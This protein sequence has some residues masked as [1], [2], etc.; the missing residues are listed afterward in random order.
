[1][2]CWM[3]KHNISILLYNFTITLN[4][5]HLFQEYLS[6]TA[7]RR[8]KRWL[9]SRSLWSEI[10]RNVTEN[11]TTTCRFQIEQL[12]A[13]L[14]KRTFNAN[15]RCFHQS[16]LNEFS[17]QKYILRIN[18]STYDCTFSVAKPDQTALKLPMTCE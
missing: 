4:W 6:I 2:N 16:N 17:N 11:N 1:M 10:T 9:Y 12:T 5:F 15:L 14:E 3:E 8:C 13:L 18:F 7:F